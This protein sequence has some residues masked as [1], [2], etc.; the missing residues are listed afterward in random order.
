MFEMCGFI[1]MD[2]IFEHKKKEK[3]K[4]IQDSVFDLVER[5]GLN[6]H[7]L[8][9]KI[10]ITLNSRRS[11]LNINNTLNAKPGKASLFFYLTFDHQARG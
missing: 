1:S 4:E 10:V 8:L 5:V 7:P 9:S 3:K 6:S 2:L 11:L